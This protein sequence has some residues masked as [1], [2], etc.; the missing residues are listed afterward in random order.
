MRRAALATI[1]FGLTIAAGLP[2]AHAAGAD[3]AGAGIVRIDETIQQ[4]VPICGRTPP[5]R[6]CG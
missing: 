4:S 1:A 5:P 3:P 2:A 6:A